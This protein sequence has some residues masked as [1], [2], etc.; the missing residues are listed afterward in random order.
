MEIRPTCHAAGAKGN[1]PP[2]VA[3]HLPQN[4]EHYM[5]LHKEK[6]Q[7]DTNNQ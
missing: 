6:K 5:P 4:R 2:F 3:C 7:H 1:A